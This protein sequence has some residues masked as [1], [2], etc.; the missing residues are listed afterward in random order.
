MS[1][2]AKPLFNDPANSCGTHCETIPPIL[3]NY[4]ENILYMVL[5]FLFTK[6]YL[7]LSSCYERN[8]GQ[9]LDSRLKNGPLDRSSAIPT[10]VSVP[11]SETPT[12]MV[13]IINPLN[14]PAHSRLSLA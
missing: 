6:I 4:L 2:V 1:C 13:S 10:M 5:T 7:W 3:P 9:S 14:S 12:P 8:Y 11:L